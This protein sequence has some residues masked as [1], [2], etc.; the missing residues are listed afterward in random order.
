MPMSPRDPSIALLPTQT[1]DRAAGLEALAAEEAAELRSTSTEASIRI[2]E[3]LLAAG[4]D[5]IDEMIAAARRDGRDA[6][7]LARFLLEDSPQ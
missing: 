6:A 2:L 4:F 3:E 1:H 7:R 5:M